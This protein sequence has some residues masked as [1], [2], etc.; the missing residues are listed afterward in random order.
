M[1]AAYLIWVV[2]TV[3]YLIASSFG[4]RISLGASVPRLDQPTVAS[5][6]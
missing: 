3:V 6:T 4:R 1:N 2:P 5:P